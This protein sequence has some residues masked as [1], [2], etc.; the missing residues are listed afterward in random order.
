MELFIFIGGIIVIAMLSNLSGRVKKL[1]QS[2]KQGTIKL[3]PE[4]NYQPQTP[5]STPTQAPILEYIKQQVTQ[6][7]HRDEIRNTLIANEWHTT[8]IENALNS[9]TPL[10]PINQSVS[11]PQVIESTPID[12]FIVWFKEDWLLKLGALLLLIGFGWLTTYAFLNNW[13]GPMGRIALGIIAGVM[14]L[15]LGWWRIKKYLHQGGIFLVLGSTVVLLTIF[16]AREIYGFF[17]PSSAL[18]V[19]FLSTAFVA[20]MSIK[21][22]SRSLALAS[23]ILAGIAPFFTNSPTPDYVGLFSYLLVVVLGAIWIV[24]LTGNR[25]LTAAALIFVVFYSSPHL[26][27]VASVDRD[28]LLLFAYVFVAIFFVTNTLGLLKL[29]D[30]KMTPDLITAA[31][32]GLFLLSWI[33]VAAPVEWQSLI[34]SAWT[35]V[36][37]VGAFMIFRITQKREPFYVYAGI[38]I[39]M[40]AAATSAELSGATLTIAYTLE[41]V[42]ISLIAYSILKDTRIAERLSLLLIWPAILSFENITSSAWAYGVFHKDFFVLLILVLAFLELGLFFQQHRGENSEEGANTWLVIGSAYAYILLWL[43]LHA[44]FQEGNTATMASLA[45][46]TI[47]GLMAYFYGLANDKKNLRHYG[48]VL[49]GLVIAR[50]FLVDVWEMDLP[51]RI[52]TFFLIGAMLIS[53]AFLGKKKQKENIPTSV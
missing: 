22:S 12:E 1:E 37:V 38:G 51:G 25:E 39:A 21:Y 45:V 3:I 16:A 40:L 4:P 10:T 17:T 20:L 9:V 28:V 27:S 53:T 29:K 43:S 18:A 30:D 5:Q 14:F 7:V 48:G 19:M 36:F 15:L 8:D 31:G 42:A 13:I 49:I 32:N 24:G 50:L 33:K 46:Y 23:L 11:A 47:I 41:S 2:L 6:G 26:F 44:A 35:V 34:I 52:T